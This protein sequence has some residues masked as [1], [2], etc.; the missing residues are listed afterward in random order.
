MHVFFYPPQKLDTFPRTL[1]MDRETLASSVRRL[2]EVTIMRMSQ[3]CW[4]VAMVVRIIE[5]LDL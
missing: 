3:Y 2:A 5:L 1:D 4:T